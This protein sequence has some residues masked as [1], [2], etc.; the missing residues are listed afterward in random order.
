MRSR[1]SSGA[2]LAFVCPDLVWSA[3]SATNWSGR[4]ISHAGSRRLR[5][6]VRRQILIDW[7]WAASGIWWVTA[8]EE[9]AARRRPRDPR[10]SEDDPPP[11]SPAWSNLLRAEL[12]DAL[13]TWNDR[14]EEV[15]GVYAHRYSDHDRAAFW[16]RGHELAD[17]VQHQL[18][19]EYE[20]ICHGPRA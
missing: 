5:S 9:R 7:D 4:L 17:E 15:L 3:C 8:P 10:A 16:Q 19:P 13:Q 18:G 20:V 11:P 2:P 14:G 1:E 6:V 12:L